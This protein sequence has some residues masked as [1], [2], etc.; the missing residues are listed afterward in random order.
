M[1]SYTGMSAVADRERFMAVY[2]NAV[3]PHPFWNYYG[4]TTRPNDV[5][6][7]ADLLDH[8]ESSRCVDPTRVY[9][10]G[11]SNGGG[12]TARLG[13]RL[14][15]RLAAIAPVAGKYDRLPP[16]NGAVPLAMFEVHGTAD[17]VAPYG[18]VSSYVQGWVARDG[19][20]GSPLRRKLD[21]R[22][23]RFDWTSCDPGTRVAHLRIKG[24]PHEWPGATATRKPP[25]GPTS[26]SWMVWRFFAHLRRALTS[27]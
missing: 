26:A 23:V 25:H 3:V 17:P 18:G 1:E 6:F 7:V 14:G 15:A 12:M 21:K 16:C 24:G 10:T 13:C 5:R 27:H 22:H 4:S 11:V 20:Q 9:A 2:P 19:C 8:L